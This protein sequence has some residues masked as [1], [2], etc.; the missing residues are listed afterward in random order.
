MWKDA[1]SL[2]ARLRTYRLDGEA[3]RWV[4]NWMGLQ[5]SK[6]V[7]NHLKSN[8]WLVMTGVP[9]WLILG[10]ILFSVFTWTMWWN[11]QST[12]QWVACSGDST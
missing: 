11:A 12:R 7:I 5:V 4:S 8:E 3:T 6:V 10:P 2:V 9:Q 1:K